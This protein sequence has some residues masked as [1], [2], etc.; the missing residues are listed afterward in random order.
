MADDDDDD[1]DDDIYICVCVCVYYLLIFINRG[2]Q[3]FLG[4][5]N[6]IIC[7]QGN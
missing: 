7:F 3:P 5:I 6:S 1:D 4:K 2:S